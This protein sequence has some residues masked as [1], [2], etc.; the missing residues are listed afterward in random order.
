MSE[1]LD[2][3]IRIAKA[4]AQGARGHST[5]LIIPKEFCE[6]YGI[7]KDV[8]LMLIPEEDYFKVMKLRVY[9]PGEKVEQ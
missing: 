4:H 1:I 8:H 6:R 7:N 9:A 2:K 5:E 3:K